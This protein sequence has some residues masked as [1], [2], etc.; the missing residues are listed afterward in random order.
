[1]TKTNKEPVKNPPCTCANTD[2]NTNANT[3]TSE[4]VAMFRMVHE[5][6]QF[7]TKLIKK[8]DERFA[9]ATNQ[10]IL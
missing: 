6:Y 5:A 1:M 10:I 7:M 9:F 3:N 2:A 8:P 4:I